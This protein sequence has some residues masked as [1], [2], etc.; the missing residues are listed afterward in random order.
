MIAARKRM[1]SQAK[2][3]GTY[4]EVIGASEKDLELV[5]R[6][7]FGEFLSSKHQGYGYY[8][9]KPQI[10]K[11]VLDKLEYGDILH[12][13]DAG[14]HLNPRGT[15]RL[16][17][18]FDLA[19][20][21]PTGILSFQ[22]TP[23]TGPLVHDGRPLPDNTEY[24]WTKGDLLDRFHVRND[25]SITHTQQIGATTFLI[26]KC[27]TS[28][29]FV[30]RWVETFTDEFTMIDNTPSRG[31]DLPGFVEHRHDQSIFSVLAKLLPTTSISVFECWY[32]MI[33]NCWSPD[34]EMVSEFPIHMKRDR[35]IKR[36]SEFKIKALKAKGK[37]KRVLEKISGR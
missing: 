37:I 20:N 2:K 15:W 13:V 24:M 19:N 33:D 18:Y 9:W 8:S 11:Q 16:C 1:C 21:A 32:P 30:N 36:E 5:F 23:P 12:W 35:G 7:R 29:D 28:I 31:S 22:N 14:C 17:E 27:P 4:S 25:P 34:W 3:M 10:V 26:K 6:Q